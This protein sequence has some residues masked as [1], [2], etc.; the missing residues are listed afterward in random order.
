[1]LEITWLGHGTFQFRLETGEVVVLDPWLDGPTYPKG[2]QFTRIDAI[3]VTHGHFDHIHSVVPLAK[4]FSAPVAAIYELCHWLESKGVSTTCPMNKGGSQQIGPLTLTMT[5]AV[6]S[7]GILDDGNI[8]Y[9]GE[10]VWNH[11]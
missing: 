11:V 4:K 9:G 6:H 2:H 10:D 1:M 3:L 8:L 5:D 7:C